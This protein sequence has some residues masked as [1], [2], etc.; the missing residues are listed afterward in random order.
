MI[1]NECE[2]IQFEYLV[3]HHLVWKNKEKKIYFDSK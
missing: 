3:Q 2:N 1:D